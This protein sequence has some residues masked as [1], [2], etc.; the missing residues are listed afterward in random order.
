[1]TSLEDT[2]KRHYMQPYDPDY[3]AEMSQDGFDPHLDLAKH[4]FEHV[5]IQKSMFQAI[6]EA[7]GFSDAARLSM[8]CHGLS[9]YVK[10]TNGASRHL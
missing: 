4:A 10:D 5:M 7:S 1:M 6:R 2:C 3:V 9:N 8:P